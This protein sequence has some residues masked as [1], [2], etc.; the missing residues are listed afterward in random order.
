MINFMT[1]RHRQS[2]AR[3]GEMTKMLE[4]QIDPNYEESAAF[5]LEYHRELFRWA[6]A[7]VHEHVVGIHNVEADG[8]VPCIAT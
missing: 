4:Q 7:V 6:A 8:D 2:I 1:R 5:D 3:G